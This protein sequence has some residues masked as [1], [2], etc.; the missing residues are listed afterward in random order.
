MFFDAQKCNILFLYI[1]IRSLL[2]T[3]WWL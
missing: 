2:F 3:I 1:Y